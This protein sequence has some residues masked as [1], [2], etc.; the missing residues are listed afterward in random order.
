M[1]DYTF[2]YKCYENLHIS[3]VIIPVKHRMMQLIVFYLKL[4]GGSILNEY[5]QVNKL[6]GTSVDTV[7]ISHWFLLATINPH[8][9]T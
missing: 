3:V 7:E 6:R 8:V 9:R 1:D 5:L 4:A 2:G